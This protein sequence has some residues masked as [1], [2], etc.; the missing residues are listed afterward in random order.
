[1]VWAAAIQGVLSLGKSL[2]S[3]GDFA[4]A[5]EGWL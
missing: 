1:M 5:G 3:E 2:G 4:L